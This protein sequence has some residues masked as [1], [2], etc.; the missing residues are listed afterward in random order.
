M[1]EKI[2][3]IAFAAF[4]VLPAVFFLVVGFSWLVTPEAAAGSLMMPLLAGA[5][6]GSQ[7]GDIG[8]MFLALGLMIMSALVWRKSDLLIAVSLVLA[9]IVVYRLLAFSVHGA[10]LSTQMVAVETVLSVWM[11]TA[12]RIMAKRNRPEVQ[13]NV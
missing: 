10:A 1:K 12:S 3:R 8:G 7:I 4:L 11:G 6:L 9:C 5:A 13:A 2:L